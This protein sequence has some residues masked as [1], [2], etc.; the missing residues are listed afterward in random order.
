MIKVFE[1]VCLCLK[2]AQID[3]PFHVIT[4]IMNILDV[5]E[6][7]HICFVEDC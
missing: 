4:D 3:T 6:P 7:G 2:C 5:S 1:E